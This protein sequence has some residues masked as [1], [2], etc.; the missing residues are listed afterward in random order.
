ML[1]YNER[2][3]TT[4]PFE[5]VS[6]WTIVFVSISTGHLRQL[7]IFKFRAKKRAITDLS[8]R[9]WINL[10]VRYTTRFYAFRVHPNTL[11]ANAVVAVNRKR[12]QYG[13]VAVFTCDFR[14]TEIRFGMIIWRADKTFRYKGQRL[15]RGE[16]NADAAVGLTMLRWKVRRNERKKKGRQRTEVK[17]VGWI[18]YQIRR[19]L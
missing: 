18:I 13:A 2:C 14:Q 4:R 16:Q 12:E 19:V 8:I 5:L 11:S 9:I 10:F 7:G 3:K 1:T 17:S 15:I 6:L